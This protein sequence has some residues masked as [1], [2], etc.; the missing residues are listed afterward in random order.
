MSTFK[1]DTINNDGTNAIDATNGFTI[2]GN[3]I[4][5]GYTSSASEPSSPSTGDLWWD[6][7]NEVL[8]RYINSEWK[9]LSFAGGS[10][11]VWYGDRQI[12]FMGYQTTNLN[13]IEYFSY[14]SGDATDF[15]DATVATY[16]SAGFSD[17]TRG[18]RAGGASTNVIDYITI[19]T[20]G[21]ATDFGDHANSSDVYM[22]AIGD[23]TYGVYVQDQAYH[24]VTVQTT[25]NASSFGST[26]G[27]VNMGGFGG[28]GDGTYGIFTA[29]AGSSSIINI[30]TIATTGS[31]TNHGN[32]L[33]NNNFSALMSDD[34]YA[35]STHGAATLD[36][37]MNYITIT[38]GGTA[39]DYGDL[40]YGNRYSGASS[41]GTY[42]YITG[43][44]N[45]PSKIQYITIATTGNASVLGD[46][47]QS[48]AYHTGTSG[49]AS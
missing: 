9:E 2:A 45:S 37:T 33:N 32:L 38:T 1:V 47:V 24:Y 27:S 36:N 28:A 43:G 35:V 44:T 6:S 5:Q 46:L 8:K 40:Y 17:G 48:S 31:A 23:G 25:G 22:Q 18:V 14:S 11:P 12:V 41:D 13:N 21:N 3:S 29:E 26:S 4:V 15:G 16:G 49:S 42:G 7:A 19:A 34:T 39:A 20:T 10:G 30:L